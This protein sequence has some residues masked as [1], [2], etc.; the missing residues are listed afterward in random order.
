MHR[1][2]TPMALLKMAAAQAAQAEQEW[3]GSYGTPKDD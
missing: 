1:K 2:S 3:A